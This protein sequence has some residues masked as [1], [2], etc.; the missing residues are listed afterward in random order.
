MIIAIAPSALPLAAHAQT[1]PV[2]FQ[3]ANTLPDAK[4][5][6]DM[7]KKSPDNHATAASGKVQC[8]VSNPMAFGRELE[9][10]VQSRMVTNPRCA[11]VTIVPGWYEKYDSGGWQGKAAERYLSAQQK[12][13]W[14]LLMQ[15]GPGSEKAAWWLEPRTLWTQS[16]PDFYR[17]HPMVD[18]G[19][20]AQIAEDVCVAVTG[21]GAHIQ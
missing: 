1:M 2:V 15:S 4:G 6:C 7:L 14:G 13:D 8:S 17:T 20:P 19:T 10:A 9:L 3:T 5:A 18:G 11:G 21:Q 12:D 16:A